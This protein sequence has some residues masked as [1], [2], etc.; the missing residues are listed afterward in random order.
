MNADNCCTI[1]DIRSEVKNSNLNDGGCDSLKNE[2]IYSTKI[3]WVYL[4]ATKISDILE[5]AVPGVRLVVL[6]SNIYHFIM[7][8]IENVDFII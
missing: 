1:K 8:L 5:D 7:F 4:F 2:P 3:N 6:E